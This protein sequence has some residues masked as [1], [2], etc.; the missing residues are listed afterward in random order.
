MCSPS[1]ACFCRLAAAWLLLAVVLPLQAQE[2][3]APEPWRVSRHTW[4][5]GA[6]AANVLD[7][8][9]SPLEYTGTDLTLLHRRERA[10]KWGKGKVCA[11]TQTLGHAAYVQSPTD[12]GKEWDGELSV[13]SG[14]LYQIPLSERWRL[15]AGGLGELSTGFTYNTRG[16]NNPAQGR[17]GLSLLATAVAEGDF[18]LWKQPFGARFQVDAHLAG[19]QFSPEYGQSYYEIFSLG[20]TSG[21]VH[22]T[23][24]GNCPTARLE[25]TVSLPVGRSRWTFGYVGDIRQSRLGGLKRHAWRH[26]LVA[27]YAFRCFK[28]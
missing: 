24:T 25:A 26:C 11:L 20:H 15:A 14:W 28:L 16:S 21:I 22:P 3:D 27:G 18:S 5:F 12:D 6:G 4:L 1:L 13:T 23:W 2:T 10:V 7:T 8:Y 9:L 19:V 17:L